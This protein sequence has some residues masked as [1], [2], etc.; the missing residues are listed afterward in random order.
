M[1]DIA[2]LGTV[3][4]LGGDML[5]RRAP[6]ALLLAS[7]L[8][9][10]S[11]LATD[12]PAAA[13]EGGSQALWPQDCTRGIERD[14]LV[15]VASSLGPVSVSLRPSSASEDLQGDFGE[16][17]GAMRVWQSAQPLLA[18]TEYRLEIQPLDASGAPL[19]EAQLSHFTTGDQLTAQLAFPGA[20]LARVLPHTAAANDLSTFSAESLRDDVVVLRIAVPGLSGGLSHRALRLEA[21]LL[22][23]T[24]SEEALGARVQDTQSA[25]PNQPIAFQL[26]AV[27][28]DEPSRRCLQIG[29]SDDLGDTTLAPEFCVELPARAAAEQNAEESVAYDLPQGSQAREL[30]NQGSELSLQAAQASA[31]GCSLGSGNPSRDVSWFLLAMLPFLAARRARLGTVRR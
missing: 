23:D 31:G 10:G 16:D 9:T 27:L 4:A 13:T 3:A 15:L 7:L 17:Q 11:A 22:G 5:R 24:S 26:Q 8:S 21:T 30:S 19:G 28:A 6:Y 12:V 1:T 18:Q 2:A 14:G 25:A 29:A 20:P